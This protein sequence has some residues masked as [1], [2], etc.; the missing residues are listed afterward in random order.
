MSK[1]GKRIPSK[2]ADALAR[3]AFEAHFK[4]RP[5]P[6]EIRSRL[7]SECEMAGEGWRYDYVLSP[8]MPSGIEAGTIIIDDP[9][10][11]P[12]TV[13]ARI[14]VKGEP[15]EVVVEECEEIPW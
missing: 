10:L 13:V 3:Q 6:D 11:P 5:I 2:L 1:P 7:G 8:K 14:Y 12:G 4:S 9:R 15:P